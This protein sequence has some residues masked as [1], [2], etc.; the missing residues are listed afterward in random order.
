[1]NLSL[2]YEAINLMLP[3]YGRV[4][5]GRLP[6]H[7]QSTVDLAAKPGRLRYT[8][9]VDPDDRESI[10][11]VSHLTLPFPFQVLFNESAGQPHLAK[12]YN[13]IY[14]QTRWQEPEILVSMI[15]DD[16]IWQTRGF[17]T[18]ILRAINDARGIGVVCCDD[19]LRHYRCRTVNA[20]IGRPFVEATGERF[21]CELFPADF[22]DD[23][24]GGVANGVGALHYL[25]HVILR[26]EHNS[27]V[28]AELRDETCRR[29]RVVAAEARRHKGEIGPL[30]ARIVGR[31]RA[32]GLCLS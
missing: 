17:D 28:P 27:R 3:T 30:V 19:A 8:F 11:Y 22:I 20:F 21:M 7:V 13:Q 15:G 23:I 24:W 18:E 14:A 12:I 26:H 29:L 16:M 10:D 25:D 6:A 31:L 4:G 32:K 9:L 2:T 1:M 5:N